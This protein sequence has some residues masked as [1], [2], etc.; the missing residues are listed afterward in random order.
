ML[1]SSK[2]T[3][4]IISAALDLAARKPWNEVSLADIAAE[5]NVNFNA[6][7]EE[8]P[9]KG[10]ILAG[11]IKATDAAVLEKFGLY[12]AEE[13]PR[14]RV[15]DILMTRFDVM[16]PYKAGLK[17]IS[18][19]PSFYPELIRPLIQSIQWML[20]AAGVPTDS[21]M[22][23]VLMAGTGSVFGRAFRKW[24]EDDDPGNAKT[25]AALDRGLRRGERTVRNVRDL[26]AAGERVMN[27]MRSSRSS[28]GWRNR[29]G[30]TRAKNN[31][32]PSSDPMN[33]GNGTAPSS[34]S[35]N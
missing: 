6:L 8:F 24:L 21:A 28:T 30:R 26:F 17:S 23:G 14:D 12:D 35:I 25:M 15:F 32:A 27:A 5:A 13:K 1:D 3:D 11:F 29:R 9:S 18:E 34:T 31:D 22:R 2:T 33:G 19:S 10:A 7:R 16:Q 4:K 20:E